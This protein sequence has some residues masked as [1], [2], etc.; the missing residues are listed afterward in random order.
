MNIDPN[1]PASV[2]ADL[3]RYGMTDQPTTCPLC[4]CRSAILAEWNFTT[5]DWQ[6]GIRQHHR[7]ENRLSHPFNLHHDFM[8]EWDPED[9]LDA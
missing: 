4:G 5:P 2:P 9:E 6:P 1:R 3:D 7:C 8:V